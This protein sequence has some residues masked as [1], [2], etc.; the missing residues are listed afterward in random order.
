MEDGEYDYVKKFTFTEFDENDRRKIT[1]DGRHGKKISIECF[2]PYS[3]N[4]SIAPR[5]V[6]FSFGEVK[7]ENAQDRVSTISTYSMKQFPHG[8]ALIINNEIFVSKSKRKGTAI[9]E[10]NLT[11][12]SFSWLSSGSSP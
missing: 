4:H 11:R 9:D 5:P 6:K 2:E 12:L 10:R 3:I 1:V 7:P 8:I